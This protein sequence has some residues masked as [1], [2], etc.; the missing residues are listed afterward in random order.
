LSIEN[1]QINVYP[2]PQL[3]AQVGPKRAR[4]Y[5]A[6]RGATADEARAAAE[7][8][9]GNLLGV[10]LGAG[11]LRVSN[12]YP[13]FASTLGNCPIEHAYRRLFDHV[14]A[15]RVADR[16]GPGTPRNTVILTEP[17]MSLADV[18]KLLARWA[19]VL[20]PLSLAVIPLPLGWR[21]HAPDNPASQIFLV[22]GSGWFSPANQ[23]SNSS[24]LAETDSR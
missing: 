1:T 16:P 14:T 3:D 10:H 4:A 9:R 11:P 6:L 24:K 13:A 22:Y 7:R 15:Y 17:Y 23:P 21:I 19:P 18:P 2:G 20:R 8:A 12:R 5:L